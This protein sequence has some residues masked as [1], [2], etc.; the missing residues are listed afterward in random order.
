MRQKGTT[1]RDMEEKGWPG[2]ACHGALRLVVVWVGVGVGG[3]WE[4]TN[5]VC[6]LTPPCPA[7]P[8]GGVEVH[9][10]RRT[11]SGIPQLKAFFGACDFP[12]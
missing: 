12:Y 1:Q 6:T 5:P 9:H 7:P 8:P 10:S 11:N 3:Y 2:V 4:E